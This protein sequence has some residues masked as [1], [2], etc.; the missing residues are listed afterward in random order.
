[1]HV[2][3]P[4]ETNHGDM[5]RKLTSSVT[6]EDIA[7]TMKQLQNGKRQW[8]V[9]LHC[10]CAQ[11]KKLKTV[12]SKHQVTLQKQNATMRPNIL[13]P[14]SMA[15]IQPQSTNVEE[16]P[17]SSSDKANQSAVWSKHLLPKTVPCVLKKELQ[18]SNNP[19]PT[20][21]FLST[22]TIKSMV[23]TG[24][25]QVFINVQSRPPQCW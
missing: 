6:F 20:H 3:Q 15:Q 13:Q 4:W 22:P 14:N 2:C 12:W 5:S 7:L 16:Q 24:I 19:D 9:H 1:M 8:C 10:H 17:A 23:P 11:I 18:F 21:N 25:N